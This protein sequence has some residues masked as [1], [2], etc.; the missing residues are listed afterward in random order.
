D[1]AQARDRQ[2][3]GRRA[4]GDRVLTTRLSGAAASAAALIR[5]NLT[6]ASPKH[7]ICAAR[8]LQRP[9]RP[10]GGF[11]VHQRRTAPIRSETA[12]PVYVKK[13]ASANQRARVGPA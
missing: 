2:G 1:A 10:P 3:R 12:N 5:V 9:V 8:R 4:K 11:R 7:N 13:N 6:S